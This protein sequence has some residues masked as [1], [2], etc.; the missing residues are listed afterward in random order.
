MMSTP[1]ANAFPALGAALDRRAFCCAPLTHSATA[2]GLLNVANSEYAIDFSII[3]AVGISVFARRISP[4]RWRR[5]AAD[6]NTRSDLL[7]APCT[8]SEYFASQFSV[9]LATALKRLLLVVASGGDSL[10][11]SMFAVC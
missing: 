11:V 2:F 3:A 8:K 4:S 1:K 5:K 9:L 10:R 7:S 6:L